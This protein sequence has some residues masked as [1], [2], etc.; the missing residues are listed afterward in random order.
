MNRFSLLIQALRWRA[1]SSLI[2][3]VVATAAIL[4]AAIGPIYLL[5]SDESVIKNTLEATSLSDRGLTLTADQPVSFALAPAQQMAQQAMQAASQPTPKQWFGTPIRT[6]LMPISLPGTASATEGFQTDLVAREGVCSHLHLI[7]GRCPLQGNETMISDRSARQLG[8]ALGGQIPYK[9]EATQPLSELTVV[10]VFVPGDLRDSY[11]FAR[12]FFTFAPPPPTLGP[13]PPFSLDAFFVTETM[14]ESLPFIGFPRVTEELP[15]ELDKVKQANLST[16]QADLAA[17]TLSINERLSVSTASK[18]PATL[19]QLEDEEGQM[20]AIVALATVQL[21]LLA[22]IVLN[23]V[24]SASAQTRE[25]EVALARLRG[26]GRLGVLAVGLREPLALL[27]VAFP[28]GIALAWL[29]VRLILSRLLLPGTPV[30]LDALTFAAAAGALAGGVA[31]AIFGGGRLLMR[32]LHEQLRSKPGQ[33]GRGRFGQVADAVMVTLAAAGLIELS[34]SGI[35]RGGAGSPLAVIAP[36]LLVLAGAV[37]AMRLLPIVFAPLVR[38]TSRSNASGSFLATRRLVRLPDVSRQLLVPALALGLATFGVSAWS[39][40]DANRSELASFQV[41]ADRVLIVQTAPGVDLLAAVRSVD[42]SGHLAMAAV[43]YASPGGNLLAV[44]SSRLGAVASWPVGIANRDATGTT[45]WLSPAT[46]PSITVRG[47]AI[48]IGVDGQQLAD[49]SPSLQAT[50]VD[51]NGQAQDLAV[52]PL[53][54]GNHEYIGSLPAACGAGCRVTAITLTLPFGVVAKSAISLLITSLEQ[55]AGPQGPW[56]TVPSGWSEPAEWRPGS[57]DVTIAGGGNSSDLALSFANRGG[58]DLLMSADVPLALPAVVTPDEISLD[59]QGNDAA[60]HAEG[61]DGSSILLDG[62]VHAGALPR[63]GPSGVLVDLTLLRREQRT[64][65]LPRV[66]QE[67]WLSPQAAPDIEQRLANKGVTV[68]S[69]DRAADLKAHLDGEGLALAFD[70]TLFAAAAAAILA[71]GSTVFA[72]AE[73]ARRLSYEV[74][75]LRA[76]G[77]TVPAV[78]RGV[79]GEQGVVLAAA[80]AIGLGGG[81]AGALLAIPSV[82][83]FTEA[84]WNLPLQYNLPLIA[85][86]AVFTAFLVVL[87]ATAIA[88]SLVVLRSAGPSQLRAGPV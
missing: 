70:L 9:L 18:L 86:G 12:N 32:A 64:I 82:P 61:I 58:D 71:I 40:A 19:A 47:N 72:L 52:G 68:A 5:A 76:C 30:A 57:S 8:L 23:G 80:C 43:R 11:W 15:L 21:V 78:V 3:L 1:T 66:E 10:G 35:L 22:L 46:E 49:L 29:T 17:Y 53:L 27:L 36:G 42:P 79:F 2:L 75:I 69:V 13:S 81:V 84:T 60:I 77:W 6:V 50:V 56:Q 73:G 31:A 74:A 26:H 4:V 39:I 67:V 59:G 65:A 41:G 63:L 44:D 48:R 83:E 62:R 16:L 7:G 51:A 37:I 85:L 34:A 54:Q 24:V 45:R 20:A 33:G 87:L 25:H 14:I 38:A 28:L 55:A 88:A